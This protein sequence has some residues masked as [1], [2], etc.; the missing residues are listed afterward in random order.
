MSVKTQVQKEYEYTF[1]TVGSADL[2]QRQS[3]ILW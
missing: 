1:R 2:G 3:L